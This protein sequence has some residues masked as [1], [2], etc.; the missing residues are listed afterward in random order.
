MKKLDLR[1][2]VSI[3]YVAEEYMRSRSWQGLEQNFGQTP[4]TKAA[5][6]R[7]GIA[8]GYSHEPQSQH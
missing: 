8:I 1:A 2:F 6:G 4:V 3:S 5:E 7:K